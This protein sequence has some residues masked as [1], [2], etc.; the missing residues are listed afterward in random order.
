VW[1][2]NE[3]GSVEPVREIASNMGLPKENIPRS[4]SIILGAASLS[5]YDMTRAY[6]T[7]AN[8]GVTPTPVLI[9]KVE[10]QGATLYEEKSRSRRALNQN[11]NY[12]MVQLLKHAS[13]FINH[14]FTSETGGKTGTSND[15]VDGWFM[16]I[17]PNLVT[18]TWVGGSQSWVRFLNISDGQGGRMSR[19]YYVEF[20]K[21][22]EA[23][24][25]IDFDK[26]ATFKVPI[27]VTIT[28]DCDAYATP[29]LEDEDDPFDEEYN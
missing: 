26:E 6:A 22:L 16:G 1:I 8:D 27:D 17:T 7:F 23:D 29:A 14:N 28:T 19:P 10:Y 21:A 3:L 2:L 24:A 13:G 12:A 15:H 20:M 4:P 5:V 9:T 18:G 11:V 25:T